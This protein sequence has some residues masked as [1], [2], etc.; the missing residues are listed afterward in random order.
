MD[1][2]LLR[3]HNGF[4]ELFSLGQKTLND[5]EIKKRRSLQNGQ[6]ICLVDTFVEDLVNDHSL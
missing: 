2:R 1:Q 6:N 3:C 4:T 5:D